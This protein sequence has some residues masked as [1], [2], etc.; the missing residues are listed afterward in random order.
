MMSEITPQLGFQCSIE[1]LDDGGLDVLIF[2]GKMMNFVSF[3]PLLKFT[4]EEFCSF[5]HLQLFR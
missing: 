5:I 1:T 4:I 3:Q 2:R